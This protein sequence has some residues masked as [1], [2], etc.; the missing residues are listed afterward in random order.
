MSNLATINKSTWST[1]W[2]IIG[3]GDFLCGY[4]LTFREI[5]VF[6]F[7]NLMHSN[8]FITKIEFLS[9]N[10]VETRANIDLYFVI[11]KLCTSVSK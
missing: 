3:D 1:D 8:D 11:T 5:K 10:E 9:K 6:F 2:L 4:F 7:Q